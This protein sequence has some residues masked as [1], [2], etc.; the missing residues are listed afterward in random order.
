MV[1]LPPQ[2][3][4]VLG[5]RRRVHDPDVALRA[6]REES[7]QPGEGTPFRLSWKSEGRTGEFAVSGQVL[8]NDPVNKTLSF[9]VKLNI[10]QELM[11]EPHEINLGVLQEGAKADSVVQIYSTLRDDVKISNAQTSSK[12]IQSRS[13]S[14]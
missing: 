12:S 13:A 9:T 5:R 8:T 7:L 14:A 6:E 2:E 1:R 10:K 11:F 3:V 4:E